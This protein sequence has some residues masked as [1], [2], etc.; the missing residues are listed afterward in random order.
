[1]KTRHARTPVIE[2]L[3]SRIAPAAVFTFTDVDGDKVKI[4]ASKGTSAE[5]QAAAQFTGTTGQLTDLDL[6][7]GKFNGANIS[8]V[9]TQKAGDGKVNVGMIDSTGFNLGS[10]KVQGDLGE[11]EAGKDSGKHCVALKSLTAASIGLYGTSTGA[12][13]I[14]SGVPKSNLLGA[15]GTVK[16]TGDFN[17]AQFSAYSNLASDPGYKIAA[18]SIGGSVTKTTNGSSFFG[19]GGIGPLVVQGNAND[20]SVLS[21]S[22][23][24]SGITI[25][26]GAEMG[27]LD[28]FTT[29]T[30]KKVSIAGNVNALFVGNGAV[31]SLHIGGSV[32]ELD[33]D[34]FK[35]NVGSVT[36]GG[37]FGS[38]ANIF[39]YNGKSIGSVKIGGDC[40]GSI[41][42]FAG[43]I[44]K[45]G[46]GGSLAG[47]IEAKTKLGSVTVADNVTNSLIKA[48]FGVNSVTTAGASMGVIK[49][50]GNFSAST[51]S[52]GTNPGS[53]TYY[54]TGD[55]L[56]ETGSAK[57]A[58]IIIGG[59]VSGTDAGTNST[60]HFGIDATKIGLLEIHGTKQT[61]PHAPGTLELATAT[62]G[63]VTL[64]L[65]G[66]IIN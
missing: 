53:D 54:G 55:D 10:V 59:T 21:S 18:V 36:V 6:T 24:L 45:V 30:I 28:F 33:V 29:G 12:T 38:E 64:Q 15:V 9:V 27:Q 17:S 13:V 51:I 14:S 39:C 63:D 52:C 19:S 57:I 37:N 31:K 3:E 61:L 58:S 48:G 60:D 46:I 11:I 23:T 1:M 22:G 2:P 35:G 50:G 49:I 66:P 47:D 16:I 43:S 8:I 42:A 34:C 25:K 41:F 4:T 26:G 40:D 7:S 56:L 5:L 62:T 32:T 44:G 20:F 65:L